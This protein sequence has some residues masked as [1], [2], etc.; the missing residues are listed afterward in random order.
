MWTTCPLSASP[1]YHAE[2]H[3]GLYQKQTNSSDISV[4]HADFHE[5]HG[6][7]RYGM[8]ELTRQENGMGAGWERHGIRELT[9]KFTAAVTIAHHL[10]LSCPN[11]TI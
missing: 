9:F 3:E 5:G 8:C 6:T 1:G 7:S 4:H 11:Q 2:V 10:L